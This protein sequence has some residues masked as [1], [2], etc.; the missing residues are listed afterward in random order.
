MNADTLS[1]I[2]G[3]LTNTTF[4]DGKRLD[5][6]L[7]APRIRHEPGLACVPLPLQE[8]GEHHVQEYRCPGDRITT[9]AVIGSR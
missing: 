5:D 3:G 1:T 4:H 9:Y 7:R 6:D 2:T 8:H